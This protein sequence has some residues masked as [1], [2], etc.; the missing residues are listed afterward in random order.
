MTFWEK[1]FEI[2]SRKKSVSRL[3]QFVGILIF[4][5]IRQKL[6]CK[7]PK[8]DFA[9]KHL[10]S[11]I[12]LFKRYILLIAFIYR[13]VAIKYFKG[14]V[15][16]NLYFHKSYVK[17]F[18]YFAILFLHTYLECDTGFKFYPLL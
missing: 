13:S 4:R 6:F 9:Q 5:P 15:F 7:F 12:Q 18:V 16:N 3:S 1:V 14:L 10:F 8:N 11:D 2:C 17:K